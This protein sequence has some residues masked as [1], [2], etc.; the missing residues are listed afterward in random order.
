MLR[1]SNF[2]RFGYLVVFAVNRGGRGRGELKIVKQGSQIQILIGRHCCDPQTFRF[3]DLEVFAVNR[4]GRGGGELTI[5]NQGS[6]IYICI[7]RHCCDPQ[8]FLGLGN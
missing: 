2:F 7:G 5:V 8:T 4:D 6:Q 1:P 3:W